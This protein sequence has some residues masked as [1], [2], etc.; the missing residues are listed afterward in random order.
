MENYKITETDLSGKGVV[1]LADTPR[2]TTEQMQAKFDEI[3][4]DVVVPKFNSLVDKLGD[5][6]ATKTDLAETVLES[7]SSDMTKAVYDADLDGVVD[8]AAALGGEPPEHYA[9]AADAFSGYTHAL[10]RYA[11]L[12]AGTTYYNDL[13]DLTD[14]GTTEA[15][16][17]AL[18]TGTQTV[19]ETDYTLVTIGGSQKAVLSSVC[20]TVNRVHALAG[21]GDNVKFTAADDYVEG[22]A[23]TVN[24]TGASAAS[25][26]GEPL[27]DGAFKSGSVV[28]C[29]KNGAS[30][31]FKTGGAAIN[32]K[33][34]GG[35]SQPASPAENTV[36]VNTDTAITE[37]VF[38]ATQ[39]STRLDGTALK[40]GEV[41]FKSGIMSV[42]A[43]NLLKKNGA[44]EYPQVCYQYI[45]GAWVAKTA[46]TYQKGAW[47]DWIICLYNR[48]VNNTAVGGGITAEG[49]SLSGD[50]QAAPTFESDCIQFY[51]AGTA[52]Y[53]SCGTDTPC[54][55]TNYTKV[56]VV[57]DVYFTLR[58]GASD[59]VI[60]ATKDAWAANT[61]AH[62][63][64]S[65]G[66][67]L[68]ASIDISKLSGSYYIGASMSTDTAGL[69]GKI[70][71]FILQ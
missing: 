45:S 62:S 12:P 16:T 11:V 6:F 29:F 14:T 46:R 69:R 7:R 26:D 53:M 33:V 47:V 58:N 9:A 27:P 23:F 34:V 64:L 42:A 10:E 49:W 55:L 35:T 48:G 51:S 60:S 43:V 66:N 28:S 56:S 57:Y 1:G 31:N 25:S 4:T 20:S 22:D 5:D 13:D 39:P 18:I 40:G 54:D 21:S 63:A 36:W 59:L 67:N 19:S 32:L 50:A 17:T 71:E 41:W 65:V 68:T 2:L 24:G 44:Y 61:L 70:Y 8:N 38:S 15:Q 37:W 52:R 30:L 3:A